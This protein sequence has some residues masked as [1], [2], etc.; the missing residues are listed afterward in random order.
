MESK[1]YY[2]DKNKREVSIDISIKLFTKKDNV[3]VFDGL[4]N[5]YFTV[6][7]SD[8]DNEKVLKVDENVF[9]HEV[10]ATFS[11]IEKY[12]QS[13]LRVNIFEI[14]A[15]LIDGVEQ[16]KIAEDIFLKLKTLPS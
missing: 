15:P 16:A 3:L 6:V 14:Q 7:I 4:F 1:E 8:I 13:S 2:I 9:T 10:H 12:L 5:R 11:E